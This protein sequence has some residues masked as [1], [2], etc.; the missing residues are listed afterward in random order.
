M[1]F[2]NPFLTQPAPATEGWLYD[3]NTTQGDWPGVYAADGYYFPRGGY[4][5]ATVQILPSYVS[6]W[7][8]TGGTQYLGG[9]NQTATKYLR[10]PDDITK[11]TNGIRYQNGYPPS[12]MAVSW[13]QTGSHR[14]AIYMV[15]PDFSGRSLGIAISVNGVV[16]APNRTYPLAATGTWAVYNIPAGNVVVTLTCTGDNP[17]IAALAWG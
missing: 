11:R 10:C 17:S 1:I 16:I 7:V 14:F 12:T 8:F 15:T 13:T 9:T 5:G 6:S 2:I 4:I 3:D